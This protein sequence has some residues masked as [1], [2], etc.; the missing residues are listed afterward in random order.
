MPSQVGGA[1][2]EML[3]ALANALGIEDTKQ[4]PDLLDADDIKVVYDLGRLDNGYTIAS[5]ETPAN[6]TGVQ[7]NVSR[8]LL[9]PRGSEAADFFNNGNLVTQDVET[10]IL[11]LECEIV[12]TALNPPVAGDEIEVAWRLR[13]NGN[14][15]AN[16]FW[17]GARPGDGNVCLAALLTYRTYLGGANEAGEGSLLPANNWIPAGMDFLVDVTYRT[18]AGVAK[19]FAADTTIMSRM[20]AVQTAIGRRAPF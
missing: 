1:G 12:F 13:D 10:R 8:L 14:M 17:A 11:A 7:S 16:V 9:A 5:A 6:L 19:N 2:R 3:R 20:Q 15:Q 4:G 18:S